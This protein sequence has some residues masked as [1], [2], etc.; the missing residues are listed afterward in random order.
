MAFAII[1][2]IIAA[3]FYAATNHID[4]Y[5][6]S[7]AVK[8]A[9]YRSLILVST[10]IAGGVMATIYLFVCGFS[11][12]FDFQSI[13]ILFIN[14][15]LYT[16]ANIFW[17]KALDRDDTIIIVIMFQLIPVFMLF[18]SPI[19]LSGQDITLVQL[20]GGGIITLAAILITYEPTKKKFDK[21]KI[22][23]LALMSVVSILYALWF[24]LERYV[25]QN[26]DFNQTTFW[27]N[28]TLFIVGIIILVSISSYR[29]SFQ[30]ML[31]T[32][33][34]KV[35][36]LNLINELLNS[37]GGVLSTFAGTT[38]SVALVSFTTQGVQPFAVMTMGILL[39]KFL[40]KTEKENISRK[41]II[42]RTVT[43]VL[44]LVGLACI[45]FG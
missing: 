15:T 44:C 23:T 1:L 6:I 45:E 7:K 25:N 27:S 14:S 3:I 38:A 21:N 5:L 33:G 9:D 8:N 30:K 31:K 17:F 22:I 39:T 20:I 18:L 19:F 35:I 28:L 26:H 11:I 32:N 2:A 36:G 16:I 24:I 42:R 43:I 41:V 10:I 13:I 34:T 4:K 40:P 37:F 29:N 12:N